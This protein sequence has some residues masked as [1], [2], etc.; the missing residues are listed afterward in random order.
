MFVGKVVFVSPDAN[1][2]NS[3]V[4]V[5]IE[6]ENPERKLRPGLQ[7]RAEISAEEQI[8]RQSSRE[9]DGRNATFS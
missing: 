6:V 5:Y 8:K 7:V 2:V 1:P 3:L 4:R 9:F